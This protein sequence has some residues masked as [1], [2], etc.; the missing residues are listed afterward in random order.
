MTS[1]RLNPSE[2]EFEATLATP[3]AMRTYFGLEVLPMGQTRVVRVADIKALPFFDFW[4]ASMAGSTML[5]TREEGYV[6]LHDWEAFARL[7]IATG[8]HRYLPEPS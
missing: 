8:R 2:A 4:W 7:F 6:Y 1:V 3:P 5:G